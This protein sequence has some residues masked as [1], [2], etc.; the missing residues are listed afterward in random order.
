[1][2]LPTGQRFKPAIAGQVNV[3]SDA[4]IFAVD[5]TCKWPIGSTIVDSK[6]KKFRYAS[7]DTTVAA[8]RLVAPVVANM[9]KTVTD[10]VVVL[11]ATAVAVSAEYPILPG[12]VGSHYVEVTL[13]SIAANQYQGGYFITEDGSGKGYCY[14]IVGNTA[15]GNPAS[16]NIRIQLA[17]PI[18]VLLSPNTDII[19]APSMY[20]DLDVASAATN[21][22]VAGATCA[23]MTAGTFGWICTHGVHSV[24]EDGTITGGDQLALST[25]VSGAVAPYGAGTTNVSALTGV[26]IVGYSV[27]PGANTEIGAVYLQLE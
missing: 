20:N 13:A 14:D 23:A 10:N 15:T 25:A 26:Q 21:W 6:G 12:Q 22:N 8:S 9:A 11:P 2:A 7:F 16:G 3:A 18:Q 17:Q 5:T 27:S 4:N 1:M 19:I 24:L